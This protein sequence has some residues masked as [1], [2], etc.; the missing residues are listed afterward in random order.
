MPVQAPEALYRPWL[1]RE[2]A[3]GGAGRAPWI[4]AQSSRTSTRKPL[5]HLWM[6]LYAEA[7]TSAVFAPAAVVT[8]AV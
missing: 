1:G 6:L 8:L 5:M 2:R 3:A 4:E 7:L